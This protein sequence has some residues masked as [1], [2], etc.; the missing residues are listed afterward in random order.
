VKPYGRSGRTRLLG[1]V[2]TICCLLAVLSLNSAGART[3]AGRPSASRAAA[4]RNIPKSRIAKLP[5]SRWMSGPARSVLAFLNQHHGYAVQGKKSPSPF[6]SH[7]KGSA[8]PAL[9]PNVRVNDPSGDGIGDQ[10]MT[11]QS[12]PSIAVSGQNIVVGY[13]DDGTSSVFY[14]AADDLTGYSWSHD[15]G[16]TWH[17]AALPDPYPGI[18]IG[19]PVVAADPAGNFYFA[20]LEIDFAKHGLAVAV[21]RSDDGGVTFHTPK[22]VS[23]HTGFTFTNDIFKEVDADKPWLTVGPNPNDPTSSIIYASWSEFFAVF[24]RHH[25]AVGTRIMVSSSSDLGNTWTNPRAVDRER[26]RDRKRRRGQ[27]VSGSNLT[28]GP[29]GRLY[30]AWERFLDPHRKGTYPLRQER[31]AH[32]VNTGRT[33]S[34]GKRI[35]S[36][37]HVGRISA[38]L[39]CSNTLWFGK[40]RLVRVQEFP[41]LG[42]GPDGDVFLAYNGA[43]ALGPHIHVARST[44]HGL[45]WSRRTVSPAG[46]FMPAM[47]ADAT[48]VDVMYYQRAGAGQ[49]NV[50]MA[51]SSDGVSYSGTVVSSTTFGVPYTLPPFDP[52]IAPC[53]MGDY[54]GAYRT[55]GVTYAAW[56]DNRDTVTN[57]FWPNGRI[58]PNVYFSKG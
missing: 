53:Y 50:S 16:A 42:T 29:R 44:D 6:A 51:R 18:N 13:N 57:A 2:L 3:T 17:D 7:P 22:V 4:E 5:I 35:A 8:L 14:K 45:T 23:I 41:V 38:P 34:R 28:V 15:G 12:E 33:F 21:A 43:N 39:A 56:G 49:L 55:N 30:V 9:G 48:G 40:S 20:T 1:A 47:G 26:S 11:T 24:S 37:R 31:V 54:N 27:F 36:P 32:S 19:D 52:S 25:G 58:D 10:D 46:A